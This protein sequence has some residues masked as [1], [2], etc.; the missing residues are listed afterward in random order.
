ML[1]AIPRMGATTKLYYAMTGGVLAFS[2]A[3]AGETV[4][5]RYVS[6]NWLANGV[7]RRER[8]GADADVALFP[9]RLLTKGV[10]WR[11]RKEK[12]Q[13]YQDHLAEFEADLAAEVAAD[14]GV[15]A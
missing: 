10:I 12:G 4:E 9:E 7:T 5:A 1:A 3:L 2:R 8:I 15:T 13:Q 14:R 6:R 11:W